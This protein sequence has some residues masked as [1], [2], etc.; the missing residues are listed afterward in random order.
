MNRP[1]NLLPSPPVGVR[2]EIA[3]LFGHGDPGDEHHDPTAGPCYIDDAGRD[4]H[5]FPNGIG[6]PCTCGE[7]ASLVALFEDGLGLDDRT[8]VRVPVGDDDLQ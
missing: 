5:R 8:R 6:E 4:V 3:N 7:L 2:H 1:P